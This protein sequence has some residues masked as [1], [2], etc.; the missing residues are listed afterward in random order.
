[1]VEYYCLIQLEWVTCQTY[2]STYYGEKEPLLVDFEGNT[3]EKF[4][5]RF[6]TN[7]EVYGSCPVVF[8]GEHFIFGGSMNKR[9]V[10]A[11]VAYRE[12]VD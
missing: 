3:Q 12:V 4:Q 6:G 7:T 11:L 9:Q 1:M 5:F 8:Q 2:K 10:S